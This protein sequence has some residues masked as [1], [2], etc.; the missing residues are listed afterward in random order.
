MI[1]G[2]YLHAIFVDFMGIGAAVH[3]LSHSTAFRRKRANQFFFSLFSFLTWNS[4][5]HFKESHNRHHQYTYSS[6]FDYE[7]RSVP[8]PFTLV[9]IVSWFSFDYKNSSAICG[10]I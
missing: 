7:Q 1:L 9:D 3:E 8:I 6:R 10:H 2:C 4:P 5:V